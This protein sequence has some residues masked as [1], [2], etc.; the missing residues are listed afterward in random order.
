MKLDQS[1]QKA[2]HKTSPLKANT[3]IGR[4]LVDV[5]NI[6]AQCSNSASLE[7]SH[8]KGVSAQGNSPSKLESNRYPVGPGGGWSGPNLR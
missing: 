4:P 5:T 8:N 1:V 3:R 2:A 7:N 6:M